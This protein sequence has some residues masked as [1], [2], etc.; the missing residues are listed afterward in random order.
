MAGKAIFS[1][2][3]MFPQ[4]WPALVRVTLITKEIGRAGLEQFAPFAA[5]RIVAG[6]AI[7]FHAGWLAA[8]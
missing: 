5:V 1:H 8:N 2:G 4:Q 6:N 7:H 3:R